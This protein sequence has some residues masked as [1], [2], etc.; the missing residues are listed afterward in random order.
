[1]VLG[2][3]VQPQKGYFAVTF[4]VI[5]ERKQAEEKLRAS[6]QKFMRLFME[7]PIPLGVADKEGAIAHFNNKFTEVFGY[8]T[9]DVPTLVNGG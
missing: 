7:I 9:G 8:T 3:G 4:D 2:I 1:M 5:T 6:E